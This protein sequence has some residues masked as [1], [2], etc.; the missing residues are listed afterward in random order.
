VAIVGSRPPPSPSGDGGSRNSSAP[1]RPPAASH[2]T[3][4]RSDN[5]RDSKKR[6]RGRG[7]PPSA[8]RPPVGGWTPGLNPWTGMVQAWPMPF[9]VPDDGVLGP[10][11]G[12]PVN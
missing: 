1:T 4:P 3:P 7:G 2:D 10:R 8:P 12:T 9:H 6:G 5:N 11:P